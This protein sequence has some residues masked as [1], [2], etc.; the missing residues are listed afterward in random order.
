MSPNPLDHRLCGTFRRL[1]VASNLGLT[2]P[3]AHVRII[4][5]LA[6]AL[7]ISLSGCSSD[8]EGSADAPTTYRDQR[9]GIEASIPA[10][11]QV[12]EKPITAVTYP[13]QVLAAASYPV[14]LEPG[15]PSCTPHAALD[16][17]PRDGAL[18]QVFEYN[19]GGGK[20]PRLPPRPARLT[21]ADGDFAH[22]EC[23]GLSWR[24][25]FSDG[26]RAFQAHIWMHRRAVDPQIRTQAIEILSGFRARQ[27][28]DHGSV[29]EEPTGRESAVP[30]PEYAGPVGRGAAVAGCKT[31]AL[32]KGVA[33][34]REDSNYVGS[35]GFYGS[36]QGFHTAFR[37]GQ[38]RPVTKMPV[39]IDGRKAV[40]LAID[41][42][43]RARAGLAVVGGR[44]AYAKIRFVPCR[45]RVRTWW[46]AG[47]KL[48][49]PAPV[50]VLVRR[51]KAPVARLEVGRH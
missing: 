18:L 47:F 27:A 26:D 49:D 33:N 13:R 9:L 42:A 32:G 21:Y 14:R 37:G 30:G 7:V 22:F 34:W 17:M 35:V 28:A 16:Q 8:H 24:F 44:H 23:A 15:P 4:G 19:P 39:T 45:D 43:D 48:A 36:R 5:P 50:V 12:I 25:T 1:E 38:R 3:M 6:V 11:W 51:G 20:V 46:P 10:A 2:S 31:A 41:P 29:K 40:T